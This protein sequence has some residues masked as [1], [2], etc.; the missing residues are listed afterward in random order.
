MEAQR[1]AL[2]SALRAWRPDVAD[3]F[4]A[5]L[6]EFADLEALTP[7][8]AEY[9]GCVLNKK[10][11]DSAYLADWFSDKYSDEQREYVLNHVHLWDV[12]CV[13]AGQSREEI[14]NSELREF[15]PVLADFWR[16]RFAQQSSL[17]ITVWTVDDPEEYGPTIGFGLER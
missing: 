5:L 11:L 15:L 6:L 10:A 8:I 4:G 1:L 16:W 3:R 13:G 14:V 12:I 2:Q 7:E 9:R 17:P